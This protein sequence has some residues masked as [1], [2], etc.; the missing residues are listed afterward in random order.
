VKA[1]G[2]EV[3]QDWL[4][5]TSFVPFGTLQNI[6]FSLIAKQVLQLILITLESASWNQPVVRNVNK[7]SCSKNKR[8]VLSGSELA[9]LWLQVRRA[10]LTTTPPQIDR[11]WQLHLPFSWYCHWCRR[12]L[13]RKASA[14]SHPGWLLSADNYTVLCTNTHIR[15][16]LISVRRKQANYE[17]NYN[18]FWK[19]EVEV[20]IP[21]GGRRSFLTRPV[22]EP[23]AS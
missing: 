22:G 9:I 19:R 2:R 20:S 23:P 13:V 21:G 17:R 8:Q 18:F 11:L 15:K 14:H 4:L 1:G 3:R 7:S 6:Y 10:N 5:F 12:D 16:R